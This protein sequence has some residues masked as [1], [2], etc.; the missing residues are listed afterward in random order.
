M[1]RPS[2]SQHQ[3]TDDEFLEILRML[4]ERQQQRQRPASQWE[5]I[6]ARIR[7]LMK[8]MMSTLFPTRAEY[9]QRN[10]NAERPR[11]GAD[12]TNSS[13]GG[14]TEESKSSSFEVFWLGHMY[15]FI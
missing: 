3:S 7:I 4:F 15:I 9:R 14:K 13:N 2:T 5:V 8:R 10:P 12:G 1:R 6:R 11:G